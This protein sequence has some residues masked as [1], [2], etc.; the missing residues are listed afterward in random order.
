MSDPRTGV[1]GGDAHL[2]WA[3]RTEPGSSEGARGVLTVEASLQPPSRALFISVITQSYEV[4]FIFI[5]CLQMGLERLNNV[6]SVSY[7]E[8]TKLCL[9]LPVCSFAQ[10]SRT[11]GKAIKGQGTNCILELCLLRYR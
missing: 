6:P 10:L 2:T 8:G 9:W 11:K 7:P 4:S 3:L 5:L 1:A